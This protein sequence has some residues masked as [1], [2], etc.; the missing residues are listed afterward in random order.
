MDWCREVHD[1]IIS[2]FP[3]RARGTKYKIGPNG[4]FIEAEPVRGGGG[5]GNSIVASPLHLA[6]L[7]E[8]HSSLD[9]NAFDMV[10][11]VGGTNAGAYYC[12]EIVAAGSP[13]PGTGGAVAWVKF[14][15]DFNTSL[16]R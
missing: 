8:W 3:N 6:P 13:E 12:T 15:G 16:W 2:L 4:V 9:Y 7:G 10:V 5:G 11:I 1:A 14:G